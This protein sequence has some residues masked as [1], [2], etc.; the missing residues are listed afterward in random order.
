MKTPAIDTKIINTIP[1]IIS[2]TIASIAIDYFGWEKQFAAV[3]LGII[4]GGLVDLDNGLTG[5]LKNILYAVCSFT[6]VSLSV[7]ITFAHPIPLALVFMAVAFIFT[8]FGAAGTRFRTVSF[9]TLAVAIYTTL[10]HDPHAPFYMNSL[11]I[12]IGTLLYSGCTLLTH[13]VFPHRPVQESMANAYDALANYLDVK[14]NF[15]DPDEIAYIDEQQ[16]NLAMTNT[17]VI[18]AFNQCR[19]ALFYRM[20]GQ[21][22]HPRTAQMLRYYF[23]AQDIHERISSSHMHYETF[24][25]QMRYTD[26]IYRIQRMIRLQ[27]KSCR[28]VAQ[29]LRDNQTYQSSTALV[30]ATQGAAQSL[31]HYAEHDS[32]NGASPYSV[33]RLLDNISRISLQFEHLGSLKSHHLIKDDA[34]TRILL[35]ETRGFKEAWRVL[36]SQCNVSS[37]VFRHAVRMSVIVLVCCVLVQM[38]AKY[39][40]N[41]KDLSA[42]Y[43]ILLTAVFVCQPNYSATKSRLLHRIWGTLGGVLVGTVLSFIPMS[44]SV[45]I[46]ISVAMLVMFFYCRTNKYSYSTFFI[47]IQAIMAFAVLGLDIRNFFVPRIIDTVL[48]SFVAGAAVYLLWADWK[49]VSLDKNSAA[50]VQSNAGYFKA[51]L[52]ELRFG[53]SDDVAY[54]FARRDSHDKAAALASVLSDMSLNVDKHGTKLDDGFALLKLDYSLISYIS[55]LGAYRD[56]I[57]Q[58]TEA[59]QEFLLYFYPIAECMANVLQQLSEW[60]ETEFQAAFDELSAQLEQLKLLAQSGSEQNQVLY[61]QLALIEELLPK[62]YQTLQRQKVNVQVHAA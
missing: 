18:N 41:P 21:H 4:A 37:P 38:V 57:Q 8:M 62:C 35:N 6:V 60:Q 53:L 51:V 16:V 13:L 1:V 46:G 19:S 9:G 11:M 58:N 36:R 40:L 47:T 3:I 32:H 56:K 26:L 45:Q 61:R 59:E 7:Q 12:V 23:I 5:K 54:R 2:A 29:S 44:T 50:A 14:A 24:T 22:R 10:T 30:R 17:K 28:E 20:R 27:A 52:H 42:G 31:T 15:F 33:Q 25:E 48:G 34:Q 55:A 39:H 43:W 49:F